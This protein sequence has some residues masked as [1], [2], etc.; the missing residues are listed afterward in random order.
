MVCAWR[1][2]LFSFLSVVIL[3]FCLN[4]VNIISVL[5][6]G[7]GH[8]HQLSGAGGQQSVV[9]SQSVQLW[10]Q[11]TAGAAKSV[12]SHCRPYNPPFLHSR[13]LSVIHRKTQIL[14]FTVIFYSWMWILQ[15]KCAE[16]SV[17]GS[18]NS[19]HLT[20]RDILQINADS[21]NVS[22]PCA[23]QAFISCDLILTT[24]TSF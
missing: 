4:F 8:H 2:D 11:L 16:S 14:Q 21:S 13:V 5:G 18:Q 6:R 12:Q 20:R 7:S 23:G 10:Q 24:S 1:T 9:V 17:V 19:L 3:T 15:R 22:Q